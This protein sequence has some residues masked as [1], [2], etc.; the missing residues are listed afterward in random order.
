[1]KL[2]DIATRAAALN[3]LL[4]CLL[5]SPARRELGRAV[6]GVVDIL[7]IS[8]LVVLEELFPG[9]SRCNM[10]T[11]RIQAPNPNSFSYLVWKFKTVIESEWGLAM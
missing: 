6:V 8:T 9:L 4:Y 11:N 10:P 2:E 5:D 7:S 1:M 3:T